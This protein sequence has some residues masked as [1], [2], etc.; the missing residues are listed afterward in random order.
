MIQFTGIE[1]HPYVTYTF[2]TKGDLIQSIANKLY[3]ADIPYIAIPE[4]D[5]L[6][7]RGHI[8]KIWEEDRK[9]MFHKRARWTGAI[10]MEEYS[11]ELMHYELNTIDLIYIFEMVTKIILGY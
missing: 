11:A 2:K 8:D 9:L 6:L 7:T 5:P 4:D 1:P 10:M 3:C